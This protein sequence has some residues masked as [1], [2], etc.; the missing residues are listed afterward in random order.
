MDVDVW[1]RLTGTESFAG[2]A[3]KAYMS[4][5]DVVNPTPCLHQKLLPAFSPLS[6]RRFFYA[7]FLVLRVSSV[8]L[9]YI[10][11]RTFFTW[12]VALCCA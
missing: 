10:I 4:P 9:V 2:A 11:F 8:V 1:V 3:L 12:Y 6:P 7:P 5:H